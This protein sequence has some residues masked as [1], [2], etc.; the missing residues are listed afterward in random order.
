MSGGA[1]VSSTNTARRPVAISGRY[2][3]S[4]EICFP[5]AVAEMVLKTGTRAHTSTQASQMRQVTSRRKVEGTGSVA[6]MEEFQKSLPG[7]RDPR[8]DLHIPRFIAAQPQIN[9]A[10]QHVASAIRNTIR[11]SNVRGVRTCPDP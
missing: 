11:H 9:I 7:K 3:A 4:R 1:S 2:Y 10:R 6:F 5:I 8:R